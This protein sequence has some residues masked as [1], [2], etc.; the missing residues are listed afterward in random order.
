MK[1]TV[2]GATRGVGLKLVEAAL[3]RGHEVTAVARNPESLRLQ[4]PK[5][6]VVRGDA[7]DRASLESAAR[8]SEAI[9][10]ALGTLDRASTVRSEGTKNAVEVAKAVGAKRFACVSAIGVGDSKEQAQKSSFVFGR[11]IMPLFLKR[12]FEDM[13]RMEDT[14]RA[15]GLE[16]TIVRPTGYTD[17]PPKKHVKAVLD[18][19]KVGPEISREDVATFMLDAVEQGQY[20]GR[21]VSVYA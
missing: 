18:N 3:A 17:K 10:S 16:W 21:T 8:G 7:L 1:I 4:H 20:L 14:V 15:S 19:S 5:L 6:R 9:L 12:P 2:I 11:I 13:A